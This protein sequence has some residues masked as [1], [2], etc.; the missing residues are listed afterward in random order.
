MMRV[1]AIASKGNVPVVG[2]ATAKQASDW[3]S[4]QVDYA[5]NRFECSPI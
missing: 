2:A 4:L 1:A 5:S 3:L